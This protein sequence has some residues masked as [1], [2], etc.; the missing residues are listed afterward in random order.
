MHGRAAIPTMRCRSRDSPPPATGRP[1]WC[2]KKIRRCAKP[3]SG[4]RRELTAPNEQDEINS[5]LCHGFI[6]DFCGVE[7]DRS[8]RR[9]AHRQVRHDA[10]LRPHSASR[11]GGGAGHRWLR[12]C[13]RRGVVRGIRLRAG[14]QLSHRHVCRLSG[15]DH[16]GNADAGHSASRDAVAVYAARRQGR[17]RRQ[18]H[19]H[20]GL[21]RQCG[22]GRA[23]RRRQSICR[24][25]RQRSRRIYT[26]PRASVRRPSAPNGCKTQGPRT[27]RQRRGLCSRPRPKR[28]G[29]CCSIRRR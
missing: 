4:L 9:G 11:H 14:R 15:A 29:P 17:R 16:D 23:R 27:A 24:S 18:L 25:R 22:G 21:P 5:S 26:A 19:E 8:H 20:T 13:R 2:Q 10:R 3:C 12:A 7:I 28:S 1:A 6:F